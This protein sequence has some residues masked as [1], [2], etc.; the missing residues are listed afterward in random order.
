ML[1]QPHQP[2]QELGGN[3]MRDSEEAR[4]QAAA[5][6]ARLWQAV[7]VNTIRD[8]VSGPLRQKHEAEEYLFG[9]GNDFLL[10][11]ES[12]GMDAQRLRAGLRRLRHSA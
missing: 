6:A 12:A 10:V 11:C 7:I 3:E 8:W 9:A 4:Q 2:E 5:G 1:T